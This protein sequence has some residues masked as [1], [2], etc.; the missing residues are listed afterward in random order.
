MPRLTHLFAPPK[1][2]ASY[3]RICFKCGELVVPRDSSV[4]TYLEWLKS[5]YRCIALRKEAD[6][7]G[8]K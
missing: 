3:R 7:A 8:D 6:D 2:G 4:E 5:P 1:K